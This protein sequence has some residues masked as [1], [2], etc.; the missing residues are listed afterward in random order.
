[1]FIHN[2]LHFTPSDIYFS[3]GGLI[4]VMILSF[5]QQLTIVALSVYLFIVIPAVMSDL[6]NM[7]TLDS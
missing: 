1:M 7:L 3:L 6:L 4:S 5:S 2:F